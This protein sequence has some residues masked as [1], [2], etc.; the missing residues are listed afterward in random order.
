MSTEA[1]AVFNA[2]KSLPRTERLA[3]YEA[4]ARSNVPDNYGELIDEELTAIAAQSF[5]ALDEEEAR[6]QTR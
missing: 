2:Y 4:I 5:T 1:Q 3:L 6:A